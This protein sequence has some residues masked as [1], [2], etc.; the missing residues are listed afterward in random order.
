M[1]SQSESELGRPARLARSRESSPEYTQPAPE[2]KSMTLV[3]RRFR[4]DHLEQ[5]MATLTLDN[6]GRVIELGPYKT[7]GRAMLTGLHVYFEWTMPPR[8]RRKYRHLLE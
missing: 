6:G 1:E 7:L 5:W 3:T 2:D 4:R 8:L